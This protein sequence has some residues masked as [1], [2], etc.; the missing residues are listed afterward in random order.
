M[1]LYTHT[2]THGYFL[3]NKKITKNTLIKV[4]LTIL[5]FILLWI[6]L[7]GI[8][9]YDKIMYDFNPI[10]LTIGIVLYIFLMKFIYIKV[11]PKIENNKILPFVILRFIFYNMYNCFLNIKNT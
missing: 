10:Y 5:G 6:I 3:K 9:D 11:I 7:L 1:Q 2:H 4:I 8:L